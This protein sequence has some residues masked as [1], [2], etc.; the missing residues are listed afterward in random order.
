METSPKDSPNEK[1]A[2]SIVEEVKASPAYEKTPTSA[3]P[4]KRGPGIWTR[5][6]RWLLGI[7]ILFGL[8]ALTVVMLLYIPLRRELNLAQEKMD[9][10]TTKSSTDLQAASEEIGRLS[11]LEENNKDLLTQLDQARLSQTLLQIRL[12]ITSA[13]L[14]L[15]NEDNAK[16]KLALSK[17]AETIRKLE[18][19]LPQ[20]QRQAIANLQDRLKLALGE[21]DKN[22]YAANSDLD[23]MTNTLLELENALNR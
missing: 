18:S 22:P 8:G 10:L 1:A 15:A 4:V 13:Q 16:A 6:L 5:L 19:L 20:S 12:D 21:L 7:L 17:T 2:P 14:A 3:K 11:S 9:S 23:V